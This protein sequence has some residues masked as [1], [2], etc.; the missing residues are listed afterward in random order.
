M[1]KIILAGIN[2]R[3]T[4]S[5]LALYCL[6]SALSG[7]DAEAVVREFSINQPV[8]DIASRLAAEGADVMALSVYIWNSEPVRKLLHLLHERCAGSLLVLGGPE[9]SYNPGSWLEAFPFIDFIVTGHGEEGF[10][11]LAEKGFRGGEKVIAIPNPPFAEMPA[12]YSEEDLVGLKH[13][14]IYYES[15]RGCPY[16]CTYCLSSRSDQNIDLKGPDTVKRELDFILRGGPSLVKFVD[17]TFNASRGHGRA[18]WRHLLKNYRNGPTTFHFEIHPLCLD[19]EDFEIL[20][21]C[22]KGLFQFEIGI[23]STNRETLAAVKRSGDWE[24]ERAVLERLIALGT[25]RIHLDLIAGLPHEDMVSFR[26]SFNDLYGLRPDHLQVGF[27]KILPGTE[28]M[29]AAGRFGMSY[30]RRAPY[31]VSETQWLNGKELGLLERISRLVDR[32]HNTRRFGTTL[33]ALA[34]R[35]GSSFDLYRELALYADD[36]NA[37]TTRSWESCALFLMAYTASRFPGE[38][39]FFLDAM[40]W[41]WCAVTR[42]PYYPDIIRPESSAETKKKGTAFFMNHEEGGG[43]LYRGFRFGISDLKRSLFFEAESDAFR[44]DHMAGNTR[45]IFLPDKKVIMYTG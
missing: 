43:I 19:E 32:L 45:A 41:D 24:K 4:H 18:I 14:Y 28:M 9:V 33:A 5:C 3:Y 36:S 30:S 42:T 31:Q 16:R 23:Q 12:P 35:H 7:I 17:R 37:Q 39:S 8:E 2:A 27:L 34:G 26:R 6:K 44:M 1:K 21:L 13:K 20:S 10:R 22:P 29:D 40:R 25:I 38:K 15:S 11:T